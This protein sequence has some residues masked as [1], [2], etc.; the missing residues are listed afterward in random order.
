M[1]LHFDKANWP[2]Y[3]RY[4]DKVLVKAFASCRPL[5]AHRGYVAGGLR[6]ATL[7]LAL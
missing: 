2:L 3:E 6:G 5:L 7:G 4:V 1:Y